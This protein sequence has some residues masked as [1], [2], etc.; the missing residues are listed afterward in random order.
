M[1][2]TALFRRLRVAGI[3]LLSLIAGVEILRA[4]LAIY[5]LANGKQPNLALVPIF[6]GIALVVAIVFYVFVFDPAYRGL[7]ALAEQLDEQH[8]SD[9]GVVDRF[10]SIFE[11]HSDAALAIDRLGNYLAVN[12]A[13][14]RLSGYRADELSGNPFRLTPPDYA[15]NVH[16]AVTK[17]LTGE[18]THYEGQILCKDGSRCDVS[19]DLIPMRERGEVVGIYGFFKDVGEIKR[20]RQ[21]ERTQRDRFRA[22]SVLAAASGDVGKVIE[23]TL[24]F[25]IESLKADAANV[26]LLHDASMTVVHGVGENYERGIIVPIEQSFSRHI[27]GSRDVLLV[28]DADEEPWLSDKARKWQPW[29]SYLATT[30][31]IEGEAAGVLALAS[32]N[33]RAGDGADS[34]FVLVIASLIASALERE[35]R[36][37]ELSEMAFVDAL[38]AL[39]NRA[40]FNE[41]VDLACAS[42][43]RHGGNFAVHYLDLDGFKGVN[44]RFGHAAGDH[45]LGRRGAVE[46]G[47]SR[48]R[49]HRALRRRRVCRVANAARRRRRDRAPG[50]ATH[51][52]CRRADH[53]E[54]R[55]DLPRREH[56]R[57]S[58]PKRRHVVGGPIAMRGRGDVPRE[59]RRTQSPRNIRIAGNRRL[60]VV[61]GRVEHG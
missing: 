50:G 49:R 8:R 31:F 14:E 15:L 16:E 45:A 10:R 38:T 29:R 48:C 56:R 19:A 46:D 41:Q 39:P 24:T 52:G 18:P 4:G 33:P 20:A 9:V 54:R 57:R 35:R 13:M 23:R 36:E 22:V 58:F 53:R 51:R 26:A 40:Y 25:A 30:L 61:V 17:A 43:R 28:R 55:D 2:N 6:S 11:H 37:R 47:A 59:A 44:D 27:I 32:R 12:A 7:R 1:V 60:R 21:L 3:G 5:Y 42:A 34:D